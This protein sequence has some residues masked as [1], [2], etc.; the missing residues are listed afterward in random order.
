MSLESSILVESE[1]EVI[2]SEADPVALV[3]SMDRSPSILRRP[4][5]GAIGEDLAEEERAER[6]EVPT[7]KETGDLGEVR[8]EPVA[9][10]KPI[11]LSP[12]KIVTLVKLAGPVVNAAVKSMKEKKGKAAA[13]ERAIKVESPT[14]SSEAERIANMWATGGA[15]GAGKKGAKA[16]SNAE[17]LKEI[18][19]L[20]ESLPTKVGKLFASEMDKQGEVLLA[21]CL[22][23]SLIHFRAA[24]RAED[25]RAIAQ[26][27]DLARQE[28]TL[29]LVSTTLAKSTSKLVETTLKE[30]VKSQVIPALGKLVGSAVS[31]QISLGVSDAISKVHLVLS[32]SPFETDLVAAVDPP[33]RAR[34]PPLPTRPHRPPRTQLQQ[35]HRTRPRTQPSRGRL[36]VG[37]KRYEG[38]PTGD[39]RGAEGDCSR[40]EPLPR[41][42]RTGGPRSPKRRCRAPRRPR[43]HGEVRPQPQHS[44]SHS[45]PL[46]P[47][48]PAAAPSD[49]AGRPC[50]AIRPSSYPSHRN[51]S[52]AL[53]GALHQRPPTR[54]RARVYV[55]LV[56]HQELTSLSPRGRLP[57]SA[58]STAHLLPGDPVARLPTRSGPFDEG[59]PLGRRG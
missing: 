25:D 18:K 42:H 31:E 23:L 45:R 44:G 56:L 11:E 36:G 24:Q 34:T 32:S 21:G 14:A 15:G 4:S 10:T 16:E 39:G 53:R 50:L 20:E 54:Q 35:R 52:G 1:V 55:T 48:P 2:V 13:Q 26:A 57:P 37:R 22:C 43:A 59:G 9:E 19:K 28:S 3:V 27:A 38:R 29:K 33:E 58:R 51:S 17:V 46:Q 47:S 6:G 7:E 8:E 41:D 12:P 40:A 30:Q 49:V 5:V